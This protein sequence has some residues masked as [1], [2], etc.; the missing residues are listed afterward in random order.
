MRVLC[1]VVR[2]PSLQIQEIECSVIPSE[3]RNHLVPGGDIDILAKVWSLS[4]GQK[5]LLVEVK[6][7]GQLLGFR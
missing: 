5:K 7:D 4:S 1:I 6:G 2:M 3:Y